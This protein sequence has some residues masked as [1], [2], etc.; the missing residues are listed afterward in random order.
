MDG[1]PAIA[2]SALPA[3]VRAGSQADKQ[4]YKTALGFE[5]VL[6]GQLVKEMTA[7]TPSLTEG[8]QGDAVTDA[9]TTALTNAGG[10]GLAPQL[11]STLKGTA[12]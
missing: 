1:L 2:D 3:A 6:L 10:I 5:Q 7:S 4:A 9:M 8:P 11:Y 12:P